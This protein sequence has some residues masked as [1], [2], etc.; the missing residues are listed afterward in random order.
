MRLFYLIA[1]EAKAT[2][3]AIAERYAEYI[4]GNGVDAE[5]FPDGSIQVTFDSCSRGEVMFGKI[6]DRGWH[7]V[8]VDFQEKTV[9]LHCHDHEPY[10]NGEY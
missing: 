9:S 2:A 3:P 1:M 8:G 7:V 5:A 10:Y 4:D 6:N